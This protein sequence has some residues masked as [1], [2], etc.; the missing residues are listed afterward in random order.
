QMDERILQN[1]KDAER[2]HIRSSPTSIDIV[3]T[4][5]LP[6]HRNVVVSWMRDVL[7]EEEADEDVFPLSVQI[8]DKFVAVAGMQ[9]D[10]FQG[11]ASACVI[12]ASKLK[13]VYPIGASLLSESTD[14]AFSSTQIVNFE[15]A[16]LRTLRW[17]IA[18]STAHEFIEQV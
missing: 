12:I 16:I 7:I 9:L 14:Y 8:L 15:T 6:H 18:L 5:L 10:I 11:I 17:Q 3:Q 13:D 4:E 1:L 2:E